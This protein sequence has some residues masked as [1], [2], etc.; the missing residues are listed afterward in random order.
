M[1][2]ARASLDPQKIPLK[3]GIGPLKE[4]PAR[5]CKPDSC[6]REISGNHRTQ[7]EQ[8]FYYFFECT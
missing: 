3:N 7:R 5:T 2:A 6:T 8:F 1:G 4:G